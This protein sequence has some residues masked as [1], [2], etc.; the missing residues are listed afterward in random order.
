MAIVGQDKLLVGRLTVTL[1]AKG[2]K[3]GVVLEDVIVQVY[4]DCIRPPHDG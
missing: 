1:E 4:W 2:H 3:A